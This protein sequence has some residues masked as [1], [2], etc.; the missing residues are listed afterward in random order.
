MPL[1]SVMIPCRNGEPFIG[2]AVR[3]VLAQDADLELIVV[4]DGSTD[5]SRETVLGIGDPRVRIIDGPRT[6]LPGVT[7]C[8]L[9][10]MRGELMARCDADD[11]LPPGRLGWQAKWM[12]DHPDFDALCGR[13]EMMTQA[14]K[15]VSEVGGGDVAEEVTGELADG[16]TRTHWNTWMFRTDVVRKLGGCRPYFRLG[17]D[18]DLMLRHAPDHRVWYEPRMWYRYR[19]HEGTMTHVMPNNQRLFLE[20][21]CRE[22]ARQRKETGADDLMRGIAE[23]EPE[24]GAS[25]PYL[26]VDQVQGVLLGR[27]WGEHKSGRKGRA[28][29]T[30]F[31]ACMQRPTNLGAW[32]SLVAL[33]LKGAGSGNGSAK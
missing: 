5:T 8:A 31:R 9:P 21:K 6:G 20:A 23:P 19:L 16:V 10:H 17:D 11:L 30:G 1:V 4:D 24:A 29:A 25:K 2:D 15:H 18:I 13:F 7:N 32:K 26:A 27:A 28:I 22:F 14:G 33:G 3:S 12:Q